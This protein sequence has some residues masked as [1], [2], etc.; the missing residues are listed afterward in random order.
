MCKR[1]IKQIA[2]EAWQKA[3]HF[4]KEMNLNAKVALGAG[5]LI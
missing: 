1:T 5:Y 4:K 3:V 2:V